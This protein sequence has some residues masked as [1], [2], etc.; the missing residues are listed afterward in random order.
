[1]TE[2]IC[3]TTC[4]CQCPEPKNGVALVSNYCPIHN[5]RPAVDQEC[6]YDGAVHRNG[7]IRWVGWKMS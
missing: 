5:E 7:G 3:P 2:C 4:D 1:M 6:E